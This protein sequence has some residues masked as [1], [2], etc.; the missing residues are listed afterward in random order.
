MRCCLC[1]VLP[2]ALLAAGAAPS[3]GQMSGAATSVPVK[4]KLPA[5]TPLNQ[6][7][8][9][10]QMLSRFTFGARPGEVDRVAAE[11][12]ARWFA[13][14]LDPA[15]IADGALDQRL[16]EF[17]ELQM[18]H[19]ELN[20]LYPSENTVS[21]VMAGKQPAPADPALLAVM[22]VQEEHVRMD[23][24]RKA[25]FAKGIVAEPTREERAAQHKADEET[26]ARI[27]AELL[28]LPKTDRFGA[29][30]KLPVADR[31]AFTGSNGPQAAQVLADFTPYQREIFYAMHDAVGRTNRMAAEQVSA[32]IVRAVVGERQLQETMTDFWFNHFNV[33]LGKPKDNWYLLSYE[34][35]TIRPH[36]LGKFRTCCWR[37]PKA[38]RCWCIWTMRFR[39]GPMRR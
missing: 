22:E 29:L 20:A 13:R 36:A 25:A 23:R 8:R 4:A 14:Q 2:M 1:C 15:S 37:Q 6:R 39:W 3:C 31:A 16:A 18:S 28:T 9:A 17:P 33:Y 5:M 11:G 10:A 35:D 26:V 7:E 19:A 27:A 30:L 21:R 38:R 12:P 32:K 34:R 24:K